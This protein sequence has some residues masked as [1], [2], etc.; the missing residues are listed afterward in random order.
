[1]KNRI[2]RR[3]FLELSGLGLT[4]TTMPGCLVTGQNNTL[5]QST[6]GKPNI[7][8][9]LADDLGY[10]DVHCFDPQHAK[11]PTPHIDALAKRGMMFTDA[12][13][14]AALCSPSRY[15]LMTGRHSWRT[16]MRQHVVG[17]YG[18]PLITAKRLTLPRMLQ[19][20][21]YHTA[22]IGKWHLGWNWPLRQ[23][24][25]TVQR[26]PAS[27]F[28]KQRSGEPVFEKPITDGPTTRGF[29]E[30]FGV[31]LPNNLPYTFIRND[32]MTIAPTARKTVN[33]RVQWGPPG[34]MA[35]EW[36]FDRILPVIMD[37]AEAYIGR[38]AKSGKPFFLY[39]PLTTP[40]EPIAPSEAFRGKSGISDVADL[41]M[42]T[43]AAVGRVTAAL[44]QHGLAE[45]TLVVFTSDNGHCSY[46]GIMPFQQLGHRVGGPYRGY[47]CNISEGGHRVP[48]VAAWPGTIKPDTQTAQ[49]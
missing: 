36:K 1:M 35:P 21:D 33:D 10:G 45:N 20:N 32:R 43:D 37:E 29:D 3:Q 14:C 22:C 46:T 49:L 38:C 30:Y 11:V 27:G 25:G 44:Q 16:L 47:K 12:H 15:G 17:T 4:A 5:G 26:A 41:I 24:D 34:P 2:S 13:A 7:V 8:I 19:K 42:E 23:K 31:D 6:A 39:L 9:I 48:M 40:H 18:T 28:I